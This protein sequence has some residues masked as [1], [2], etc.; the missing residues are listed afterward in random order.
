M[1]DIWKDA[2]ATWKEHEINK[3]ARAILR[4]VVWIYPKKMT[5]VTYNGYDKKGFEWICRGRNGGRIVVQSFARKNKRPKLV[6]W[7]EVPGGGEA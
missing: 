1:K 2:W 3:T 4:S 6:V 7:R 5:T